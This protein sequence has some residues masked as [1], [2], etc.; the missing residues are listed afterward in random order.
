V[1]FGGI[2]G[3]VPVSLRL[4]GSKVIL[5]CAQLSEIIPTSVYNRMS[6]N[7]KGLSKY[8]NSYVWLCS[9]VYSI[10]DGKGLQWAVPP[11]VMNLLQSHL[12]CYTELFAS[13]LNAYN[14]HYYSLYPL[15]KVFGSKGNFFTAPD[16][17]FIEGVYQVN[18]PFIDQLFTKT[19]ERI[20]ELLD[21]ADATNRE[22]TFIYV[23]PEWRNF[24]TYD[25]IAESRFCVKRIFL[26]SNHHC[27]YQYS[28]GSYIPA[29]FG[30]YMFFLSTNSM[31]CNNALESNIR[32]AFQRR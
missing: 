6:R 22:L 28:T 25:M 3:D 17:D 30:S 11:T 18:P 23:M 31:I 24:V 19:S 21:H 2:H 7:Y 32:Y 9:A 13:P 4:N 20:L 12:C 27:Y 16:S 5:E 26:K 29:R 15:D 14:K 1:E 10:L 8:K